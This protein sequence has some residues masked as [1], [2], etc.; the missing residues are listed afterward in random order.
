M[1]SQIPNNVKRKL[2]RNGDQIDIL[3]EAALRTFDWSVARSRHFDIKA[4]IVLAFLGILLLPS[5][6]IWGW[7]NKL[8]GLRLAPIVLVF[9][10]I[11]FC[12]FAV[13]P[14][15]HLEHPKLPILEKYYESD[16]APLETKAELF[17]YY[18]EAAKKNEEVGKRKIK[19]I[20]AALVSSF[21]AFVFI[22]IQFV[23]K[24][25]LYGR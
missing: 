12:L 13:L 15:P 3:F 11:L 17:R 20:Q 2:E 19:F 24:G 23:I 14:T 4:S 18:E 10:G 6:D 22:L 8:P 5:L 9:A 7:S 21:F 16:R 25:C 1:N